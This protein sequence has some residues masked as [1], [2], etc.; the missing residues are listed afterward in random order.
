MSQND[1]GRR[2]AW[3]NPWDR[4]HHQGPTDPNAPSAWEQPGPVPGQPDPRTMPPGGDPRDGRP[5]PAAPGYGPG[6]PYGS[7]G[8]YGGGYPGPPGP[9]RAT[10][11]T[12]TALV[13]G[14]VAVVV[15]VVPVV[16]FLAFVIGLAAVVLGIVGLARRQP[17]RGLS[18]AGIVTGVFALLF[19]TL[20]T[21]ASVALFGWVSDS[22]GETAEF[23]FEAIAEGPATATYTLTLEDVTTVPVGPESPWSED[24]QANP[25]FGTITVES[26]EGSGRVGCRILDAEGTVVD[27]EFGS[28]PGASAECHVTDF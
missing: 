24:V 27:E 28:G 8:G 4:P 10:G 21:I 12:I 3:E 26:D 15:S 17:R 9:P 14:I 13:L 22:M 18:I 11:L 6:G 16:H 5:A 20:W 19:A 2:P 25:L 23:R 1:D 7:G